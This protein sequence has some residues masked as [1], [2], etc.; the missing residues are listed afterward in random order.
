MIFHH[1]M[2]F[3]RVRF[4]RQN[5]AMRGRLRLRQHSHVV[6]KTH[7]TK[8]NW[9]IPQTTLLFFLCVFVPLWLNLCQAVT[10]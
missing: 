1:M 5:S 2:I 9:R 3:R 8:P 7:P 6:R 10:R 4:T